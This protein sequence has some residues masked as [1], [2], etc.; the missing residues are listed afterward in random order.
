MRLRHLWVSLL[1]TALSAPLAAADLTSASFRLRFS[2]HNSGSAAGLASTAQSPAIGTVGATVAEPVAIGR[3][4]GPAGTA[5]AAGFWELA[6]DPSLAICVNGVIEGSEECDDGNLVSGD[7]CSAACQIEDGVVI[8]GIAVGGFS[9]DFAIDGVA[10]QVFTTAGQ[11]AAQ[12]VSA[13]AS[14]IN[15]NLVLQQLGTTAFADSNRLVTNGELTSLNIGD[16]G[17][18]V[19]A[20]PSLSPL[21]LVALWTLLVWSGTSAVRPRARRASLLA[22]TGTVRHTG[23]HA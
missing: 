23:D 1:I 4:S 8:V 13:M 2:N 15:G 12:V 21:A 5:V 9:V 11:T 6:A 20:V 7:G 22:A 14:E 16:P 10:L 19:P 17:L 3:S 18:G